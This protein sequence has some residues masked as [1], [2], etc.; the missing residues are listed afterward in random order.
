MQTATPQQALHEV[1]FKLT[2]LMGMI[3]SRDLYRF[4][5]DT[6]NR[7]FLERL[8][9]NENGHAMVTRF[10]KD[11]W[12]L[13]QDGGLTMSEGTS[14]F[15]N[16]NNVSKALIAFAMQMYYEDTANGVNPNKELFTDLATANIGSGGVHFDR[17]DVAG[18]LEQAK[19]YNLYFQH[20]LNSSTFTDTER[21][22]IQS[23]LSTLR[24]W[25]V[26]AGAGGMNAAD[27]HNRGA[28]MLG[29]NGADNL[30]G[31]TQA[32][33]LLGNAGN[34]VLLGGIG[35]DILLGQQ[36]NDVLEGGA[37]GDTLVGGLDSD[38]L[39]GDS[40]LDTYIIRRRRHRHDRGFR[41]QGGGGVRWEGPA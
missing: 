11:L 35:R 37:D 40:G 15:G 2:D 7:N 14:V 12:K 17:A 41:R 1:T 5:T 34:D 39:R 21:Q 22:L 16:L 10:T 38:I 18:V 36:G 13:A 32:D 29:G 20:Y 4:D 33:L 6:A 25:Y 27:P 19:G 30:T 23:L 28:F 9:Q 31:G 26:Q 8:V 3:F 24:D